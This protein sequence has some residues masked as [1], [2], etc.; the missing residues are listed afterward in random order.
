MKYYFRKALYL[1]VFTGLFSAHAGSYDDFFTAIKRND[2]SKVSRIIGRGFDV[3]TLNDKGESGLLLAVRESSLNVIE[4]LLASANIK[5]ESRSA[6]DESPLM[7]AAINGLTGV[8]K[9]L[10]A[11]D[12]DVNKPGWTALHYA[13]AKGHVDIIN[14]LLEHHAYIDAESPNGTTPLMMAAE[15]GTPAAVKLLLSAGADPTLK[16][17]QGLTALNFATRGERPDAIKM[18][19]TFIHTMPDQHIPDVILR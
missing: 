3:N 4:V 12:A 18:L 16:N 7:L 11:A 19:S 14:L 2:S 9:Q 13:A 1:F 6:Q 8:C 5:V 17:A 10:I 15:Y